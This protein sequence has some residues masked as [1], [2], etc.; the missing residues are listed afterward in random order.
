MLWWVTFPSDP[1]RQEMSEVL[2]PDPDRSIGQESDGSRFSWMLSPFS[3]VW[4]V[5]G[6]GFSAFLFLSGL[7]SLF[8]PLPLLLSAMSGRRN[9]AILGTAINLALI[10]VLG[11]PASLWIYSV[12][13]LIPS[14]VMAYC[15]SSSK[16]IEK[17]LAWTLLSIGVVG[18]AVLGWAYWVHHVSLWGLATSEISRWLDKIIQSAADGKHPLLGPGL[19]EGMDAAD[20][21]EWKAGLIQEIPSAIATL[22]LVTFWA[23]LMLLLRLNIQGIQ[24]KLQLGAHFF[25]QWR[26]PDVLVWPTLISG[27]FILMEV[28][29][30]SAIALNVFRFLMAVYAIQGVSILSYYFHAWKVRGV[31][32]MIGFM[33]AIFLMTPLLLSLGFFD[34]WFDFRKKIRQS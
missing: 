11:G 28:P 5:L 7:F 17:A 22:S 19:G 30:V 23:N 12:F 15:L 31:M 24:A 32:R 26:V 29:H 33:V 20:V 16:S 9:W 4:K 10:G 14:W 25:E 21:E 27:F 1:N 6:L 3:W 18:A 8:S 13:I 34:L 2:V